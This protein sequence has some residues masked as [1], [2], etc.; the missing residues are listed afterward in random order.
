MFVPPFTGEPVQFAPELLTTRL[1]LRAGLPDR[2]P[3][4]AFAPGEPAVA[5]PAA[6]TAPGEQ[7]VGPHVSPGAPPA[8]AVAVPPAPAAPTA[9]PAM[10]MCVSVPLVVAAPPP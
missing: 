4:T 10:V 7:N 3:P 1:S 9:F 5:V 6:P 8:P 2:P